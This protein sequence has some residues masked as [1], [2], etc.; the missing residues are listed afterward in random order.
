MA[1]SMNRVAM[2]SLLSPVNA[3]FME[4]F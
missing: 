2:G 3:N 1:S 4:D